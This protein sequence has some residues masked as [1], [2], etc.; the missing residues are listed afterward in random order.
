MHD[1]LQQLDPV[2]TPARTPA[3]SRLTWALAAIA[4]AAVIATVAAIAPRFESILVLGAIAWFAVPGVLA[5]RALYGA[6]PGA[7]LAAWLVGPAAGYGLSLMALLA[8]WAAGGRGPLVIA[9][10]PVVALVPVLAL[11]RMR[12]LLDPPRLDRRDMAFVLVLLLTVPLVVGRPF[13]KVAEPM[14]DGRAYR[15]Y[16][17][18]DFV[19]AMV[20]ANEVSK[21]DIPPANPFYRGDAL[22]YYWSSHL[23]AAAEYR[24]L[25]NRLTVEQVL[26]LNSVGV[27]LL[28]VAFFY[29]FSRHFISR[30]SAA[31]AGCALALL[32]AGFEGLER[33]ITFWRAGLP[34]RLV[35]EINIDAVT[36][37][38]YS[39][40]PVDG[41]HRMFLYQSHHLMGYAASL[42]AILVLAG[43][44]DAGRMGVALVTG[45]LLAVSLLISS[46]I[47]V[48]LG[49]VVALIYAWRLISARAW[50]AIVPCALGGAVP[51]ALA[52][53]ASEA[54]QYVDH[55]GGSFL[56]FG[57][58]T[59]A[60]TRWPQVFALSF[61][62]LLAG[63]VAGL[64]LALTRRAR[65]LL[66]LALIVVVS[67]LFYFLVDVPDHQGVWVG[68]R[69]GHLL[70]VSS[71]VLTAF[72]LQELWARGLAVR[73]VTALT[74]I[75]LA[76]ASAP[77]VAIDVY[78]AQY[79]ELRRQGPGFPWVLVLTP[80]EI[81]GLDWLQRNT[82]AEA[83]VQV[84]AHVR[85]SASWGYIPAFAKRRMSAGQTIS[86]APLAKYNRA[87]ERLHE[88]LFRAPDASRAHDAAQRAGID[89]IVSGPPERSDNPAF[90]PMLDGS[91]GR[92]VPV[93]RNE[94]LSIYR[95]S[96]F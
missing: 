90:E 37:W 60:T 84:D 58:N 91:N 18:A 6:G 42:A 77:T 85:A 43:A 19:W 75:M 56:A 14:P 92:F 16:F 1:D 8:M 3:T 95:V 59:S 27:S 96:A 26:L 24:D 12:P 73:S 17:T 50:G 93:F 7:P 72:A 76:L 4:S 65:H 68:W 23:L 71:G 35:N 64:A 25:R 31:A 48:M 70:I 74:V 67:L 88:H 63:A 38:Y 20:V 53:V 49:I 54:L 46:F 61:G 41:L 11:R 52:V 2:L 86:M 57:P 40:M 82:P 13:A 81:E 34:L 87:S 62:P 55:T 10:S 39:G 29:G 79:V 69:A 32:C 22:R 9:A 45:S 51:V 94:A 80:P 36:R 83:I 78:N 44:R 28:F 66:P 5:M 33:L 89:Y 30:P 47:A 15:A 21:G